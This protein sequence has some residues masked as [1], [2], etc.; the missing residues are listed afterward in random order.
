MTDIVTRL[1]ECQEDVM[2]VDHSEIPKLW[3]KQAADEI[4]R[5]TTENE[6]LKAALERRVAVL[7]SI[8]DADLEEKT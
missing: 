8:P 1:R 4:E 5:L 2:W 7:S 3:C 6:L